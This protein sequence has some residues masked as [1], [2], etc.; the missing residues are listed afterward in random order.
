MKTKKN[1]N[2]VIKS[3]HNIHRVRFESKI[4]YVKTLPIP[5]FKLYE[6]GIEKS[7]IHF[8]F[9]KDENNFLLE[10]LD[11]AIKSHCQ[12]AS[13]KLEYIN[14]INFFSKFVNIYFNGSNDAHSGE[15]L[16]M[17][18]RLT[19]TM[20]DKYEDQFKRFIQPHNLNAKMYNIFIERATKTHYVIELRVTESNIFFTTDKTKECNSRRIIAY[21]NFDKMLEDRD[22]D[23]EFVILQNEPFVLVEWL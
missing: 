17:S 18:H 19:T 12:A 5:A 7:C 8:G 21:D 23:S 11:D 20:M 13:P 2:N 22:K 10:L 14:N 9:E 15:I 6:D 1:I 3:H 16:G 4:V